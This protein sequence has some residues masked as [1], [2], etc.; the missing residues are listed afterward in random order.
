VRILHLVSYSLYSGPLPPTL[1]LARAQRALG[2]EVWLAYDVKRGKFNPFE[3]DARP[4]LEGAGL[5]PPV[6]LTLSAKSSLGEL[7]RDRRTLAAFAAGGEVDVVHAHLSHDHMLAALARPRR[8][9]TALV[10]TLHAD[11]SLTRRPGQGWLNRRAD[12]WITRAR[13][14]RDELLGRFRLPAERVVTIPS[15]FDPAPFAGRGP[16]ERDRARST[17]GIPAAAKVVA[18]VALIADRGQ[19]DLARA[20]ALMPVSARPTA[21]FVGRGE[22]EAALRAEIDRLGLAPWVRFS[23]YLEGHAALRLAYAAADVAFLARPGNDGSARAG[24][25]A[26]AASVPL[27]AVATG[28]LA[29]LVEDG[30]GFAVPACAPADIARLVAQA[31]ADPH[32]ARHRAELALAYLARERSFRAEA[33]A[34]QDLYARALAARGAT[35]SPG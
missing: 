1:G 14:H 35:A 30:R 12:G 15:G 2:H 5:E 6:A 31:L 24:L 13:A 32:E 20:L 17:F 23:G 9:R 27:V 7:W 22:G 16:A 26:M 11:R 25:E 18:Q 34:T 21:L 10:R 8:G 29:D 33:E 3:E 19:L 4:H 28:A